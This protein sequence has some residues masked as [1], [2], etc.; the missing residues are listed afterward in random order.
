M[1]KFE[2]NPNGPMF[3]TTGF[4][5]WILKFEF[6]SKFVLRASDFK[7]MMPRNSYSGTE[8]AGEKVISERS[9]R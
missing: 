4:M 8:R 9:F 3:E 5:F 6:V 7:N 2:T 1:S